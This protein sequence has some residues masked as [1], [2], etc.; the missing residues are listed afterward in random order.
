MIVTAGKY[1]D[2]RATPSPRSYPPRGTARGDARPTAP[3][4]FLPTPKAR[5]LNLREWFWRE[6]K[7]GGELDT[8]LK[9]R[10]AGMKDKVRLAARLMHGFRQNNRSSFR[11]LASVPAEL[12]HRWKNEDEHFW[13]DDNNL[14]SLKRDNDELPIYVGPRQMPRT[15]QRKTYGISGATPETR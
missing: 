8:Y 4:L 11:R 15:A 12:Y 5:A 3:Q 6:L 13:E 1:T 2:V 14:R 9:R 7:D 10:R